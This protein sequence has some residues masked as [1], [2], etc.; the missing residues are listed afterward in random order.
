VQHGG[1]RP[2][3]G[4]KRGSTGSVTRKT[5]EIR[6]E[7]VE[8][9]ITPLEVMLENMRHWWEKGDRDKAQQCAT[10]AAAYVHPRLS[11]VA[12]AEL[13]DAGDRAR[14]ATWRKVLGIVRSLAAANPE[15]RG[16]IN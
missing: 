16:T 4:R 11:S 15:K 8:R 5:R 9:G 14:L 3:A 7:A 12:S 1:A 13:K 6:A 10:D 2:G